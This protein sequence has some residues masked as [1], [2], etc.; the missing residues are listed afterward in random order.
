M[1][2]SQHLRTRSDKIVKTAIDA[3]SRTH[4]RSYAEGGPET[5]TK[6]IQA[7]YDHLLVGVERN[8]ASPLIRYV[9][10]IARERFLTGVALHEIQTAINLLEEAIW[11]DMLAKMPPREF[12]N[13]VGRVSTILGLA[14][15]SLACAYVSL[16]SENHARAVDLRALRRGDGAAVTANS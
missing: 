10:E 13:A 16:A 11:N 5:T 2:T 6:R 3:L 14:K 9:A 4:L 7:L 1:D 8:S 15:D 12:A